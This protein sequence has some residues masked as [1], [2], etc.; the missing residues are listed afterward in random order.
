MKNL[1]DLLVHQIK[2]IYNAETVD[3]SG[4]SFNGSYVVANR[5]LA[6]DIFKSYRSVSRTYVSNSPIGKNLI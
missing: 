2:D 6:A 4:V 5:N 3:S 1:K